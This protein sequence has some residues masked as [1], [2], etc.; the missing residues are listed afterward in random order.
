MK[1]TYN[2]AK[3]EAHGIKCDSPGCKWRNDN[4]KM[5]DYSKWLNAPCPNCGSNLLTQ[6][7]F[8]ATKKMVSI[9]MAINNWCNKWLPE[10]LLKLISSEHV[11][12]VEMDGS[13]KIRFKKKKI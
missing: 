9:C 1:R 4:V 7:D 13:G 12:D 10:F 6:K 8:D 5:V 11:T 3:F 2:I